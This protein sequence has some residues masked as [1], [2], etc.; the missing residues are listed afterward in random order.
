VR[1]GTGKK[2]VAEKYGVV[3]YPTNYILDKNGKVVAALVGFDE[4]TL[5][6]KLRGLGFKV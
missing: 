6:S 4:A 2:D 3:A 5:K 1:N